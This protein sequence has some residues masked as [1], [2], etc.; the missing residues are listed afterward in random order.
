MNMTYWIHQ[1][2]GPFSLCLDMS[3]QSLASQ[4]ILVIYAVLIQVGVVHY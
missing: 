3:V 4:L 2:I 1:Q